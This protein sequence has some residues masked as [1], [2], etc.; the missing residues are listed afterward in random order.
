MSE[1][2]R[3]RTFHPS[4]DDPNSWKR[5]D[6]SKEAWAWEAAVRFYEKSL[7]T[8]AVRFYA[9]ANDRSKVVI[10]LSNAGWGNTNHL[11]ETLEAR[12]AD[13]EARTTKR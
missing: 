11:E 6:S 2:K 7:L 12:W 3:V 8:A 5:F 1:S 9:L 13:I 10:L 4:F